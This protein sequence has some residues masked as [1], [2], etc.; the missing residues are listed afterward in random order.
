[1]RP[2]LEK[3]IRRITITID[4]DAEKTIRALAGGNLSAGIRRAAEIIRAM[5]PAKTA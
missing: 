1:M 2:Y 3:P 5:D 4:A